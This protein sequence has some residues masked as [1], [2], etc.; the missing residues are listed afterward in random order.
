MAQPPK[1]E[2]LVAELHD[3]LYVHL[4]A[5]FAAEYQAK[6]DS[7]TQAHNYLVAEYG[8]KLGLVESKL[9]A[10]QTTVDRLRSAIDANHRVI[11]HVQD[12][13]RV[14]DALLEIERSRNAGSNPTMTTRQSGALHELAEQLPNLLVMFA[15]PTSAEAH[16]EY[17]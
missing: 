17:R 13:G 4:A 7:A 1:I 15:L 14:K 9:K 16:L 12:I 10:S 3:K 5:E 8:A 6:L 11:Y 2:A